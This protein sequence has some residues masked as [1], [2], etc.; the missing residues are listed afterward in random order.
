MEILMGKT[1]AIHTLGC[2]VNTYE[3]DAMAEALK[4]A[5][6]TEKSFGEPADVYLINTCTVTN[7]A[8]RKSRQM[9]RRSRKMNPEAL[10]VAAGCYVD[11]AIKND[12]LSKLISE[13]VIDL[14]IS[15]REKSKAAGMILKKLSD[16][17]EGLS[18]SRQNKQDGRSSFTGRDGEGFPAEP[19]EQRGELFPAEPD[20]QDSGLFLTELDGHT[21]AFIKVQDGCN[22]FCTY[23]IIPYVR[24][25]LNSRPNEESVREI[26]RLAEN[27][28]A[29]V[30]LTGIHL[31]SMG[32]DLLRLIDAVQEI[33]GIKRIRLGSL[34]PTLI[35]EH[36]VRAF[37][38]ADKLCPHFHL[39]LQS[40]SNAV[41]KRMN[42]HYT[43]ERYLESCD[44]LRD[45]YEHPAITTDIIVGFPGETEK[46]FEDTCDLAERAGFYE[47]HIFKY[48]RR[49][50]TPA[51]RMP[52]QITEAVKA[53]RSDA[54]SRI[55]SR[56]SG[57]FRRHYLGKEVEFLSEELINIGGKTYETGFTKEYV[58][59][60]KESGKLHQ[61]ELISGK[62]S[63]IFYENFIDES[64]IIG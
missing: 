25:R 10:I 30:V 37:K 7:I 41:L 2:K 17:D 31:S 51:D 50:G 64:I 28:T 27:G 40:G 49:K 5:G 13:G 36:T 62:A 48:S 43:R 47:A 55:T 8:D 11:D 35:D 16:R 12:A 6:F 58:R 38:A 21:R 1:F 44:V 57:E 15:N 18:G 26:K 34:E 60:L 19:D 22:M 39:S 56:L 63:Q 61:N 52:E 24:G 42:R 46:E 9:L 54:L 33:G 20:G 59:C 4:N 45:F 32:D 3:S 53:E 29:E 14:A 23:C